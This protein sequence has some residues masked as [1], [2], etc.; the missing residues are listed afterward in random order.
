MDS[1]EVLDGCDT[2]QLHPVSTQLVD[3]EYLETTADDQR[4]GDDEVHASAAAYDQ[5]LQCD[6]CRKWR[7]LRCAPSELQ[8]HVAGPRWFCHLNPGS[9]LGHT[10]Y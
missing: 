5:W 8:L 2:E 10:T 7:L 4:Q 6:A 3:V 9:G 1:C